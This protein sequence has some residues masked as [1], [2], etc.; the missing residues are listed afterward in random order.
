MRAFILAA[1]ILVGLSGLA[2]AQSSPIEVSNAWARATVGSSPGGAFMTI[3]NKGT[4]DDRLIAASSSVAQ[5]A[6]LHETKNVNG[7]MRMP[8]VPA[9]EIKAGA[10]LMLAPGGFHIML[11]GLKAPLKQGES[12]PIT[13]TFEKAGKVDTM[14]KVGKPGAMTGGDMNGMNMN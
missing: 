9:L 12:F 2:A 10:K 14:V 3:V 6:A 7:V 11:M 13:L 4:T 8:L 5:T 1:A